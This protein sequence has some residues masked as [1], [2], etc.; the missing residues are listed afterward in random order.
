MSTAAKPQ[1]AAVATAYSALATPRWVRSRGRGPPA[2]LGT[3]RRSG[4]LWT[5][6]E[7]SQQGAERA[8]D[9]RHHADEHERGQQA[10]T[11]RERRLD[12]DGAGAGLH[13]GP[14]VAP[15]VLGEPGG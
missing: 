13:P 12:A 10:H 7:A 11:E 8:D 14:G 5:K 9:E 1:P 6:T 15:E 2:D 3:R 4:R